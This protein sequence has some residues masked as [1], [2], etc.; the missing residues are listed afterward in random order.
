M[1]GKVVNFGEVFFYEWE[2]T[3]L[4]KLGEEGVEVRRVYYQCNHWS[5]FPTESSS[6]NRCLLLN[7]SMSR[8]CHLSTTK[9]KKSIKCPS[10]FRSTVHATFF[11]AGS[12]LPPMNEFNNYCSALLLEWVVNNVLR[13]TRLLSPCV[14][15]YRMNG[16]TN[17]IAAKCVDCPIITPFF[18]EIDGSQFSKVFLFNIN[19]DPSRPE[20]MSDLN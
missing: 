12:S 5:V 19:Q 11:T 4:A 14:V 1:E 9:V 16:P 7:R 10:V 6:S 18:S 17:N 2:D 8:E 20:S 13:N 15:E 3:L